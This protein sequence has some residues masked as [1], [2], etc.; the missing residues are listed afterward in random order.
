MWKGRVPPH[1]VISM[2]GWVDPSKQR[3]QLLI[4]PSDYLTMLSKVVEVSMRLHS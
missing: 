1:E 3:L 2:N 4:G